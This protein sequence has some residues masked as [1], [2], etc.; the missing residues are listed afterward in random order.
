LEAQRMATPASVTEL[1]EAEAVEPDRP[2][3]DDVALLDCLPYLAFD[4]RAAPEGLLRKLFEITDL[5]I[6]LRAGGDYATITARMPAGHVKPAVDTME[7]IVDADPSA[8]QQ[9]DQPT[10]AACIDAVRAPGRIRTCAPAS[11]GRC[12]IP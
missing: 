11:G 6:K 7:K 12:S 5:T 8:G 10:S 4:P 1:D 3:P 9:P 2:H